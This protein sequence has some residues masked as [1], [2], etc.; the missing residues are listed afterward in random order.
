MLFRC[1]RG[2]RVRAGVETAHRLA[3]PGSPGRRTRLSAACPMAV[4]VNP[5]GP[6]GA[7]RRQWQV[8]NWHGLPHAGAPADSEDL[9]SPCQVNAHHRDP[10]AEDHRLE[11]QRKVVLDHRVQACDLLRLVVTVD[12]GRLDQ[13]VEPCLAGPVV[14]YAP[15]WSS[16]RASRMSKASSASSSSRLGGVPESQV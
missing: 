11:R 5:F 15:S 4:D 6:S 10:H 14:Y 13:P 8:E 7:A 3:A 16:S 1:L 9:I 2:L 12:D